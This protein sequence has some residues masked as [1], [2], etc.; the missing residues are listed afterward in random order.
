MEADPGSIGEW[1][2]SHLFLV[3]TDGEAS[4]ASSSG[5]LS[6]VAA[7]I[8]ARL[9]DVPADDPGREHLCHLRSA[10]HQLAGLLRPLD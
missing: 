7:V 4:S 1:K 8:D 5:V 6:D 10:L 3:P 2:L 9:P